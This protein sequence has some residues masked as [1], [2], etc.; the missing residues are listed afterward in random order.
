MYFSQK[1]DQGSRVN[2]GCILSGILSGVIKFLMC[3]AC[4]VGANGSEVRL[5]G[6]TPRVVWNCPKMPLLIVKP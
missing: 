5:H 3:C 6:S 2:Q 1:S 4:V